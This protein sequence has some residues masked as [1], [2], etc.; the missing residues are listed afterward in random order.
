MSLAILPLSDYIR[1]GKK[2]SIIFSLLRG[3]KDGSQKRKFNTFY[4][5]SLAEIVNGFLDSVWGLFDVKDT[6]RTGRLVV[7]NFD[8]NT[9]IIEIYRHV[10]SCSIVQE[11]KIDHKTALNHLHKAGFKKKLDVWLP[12]Q[13]TP[14][15]RSI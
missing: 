2:K 6:H 4:S 3:V 13:L 1:S 8:K 11:L 10:S 12:H 5:F 9:E 7:E 15:D 14:K